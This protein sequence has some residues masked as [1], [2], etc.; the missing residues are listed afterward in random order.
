LYGTIGVLTLVI[1]IKDYRHHKK[2]HKNTELNNSINK[3]L[4][5]LE[6]VDVMKSQMF[7]L[8][9]KKD[10]ILIA[11]IDMKLEKIKNNS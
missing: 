7:D 4:D 1:G 3:D 9:I 6:L 8:G 5:F 10:S 2:C 11:A